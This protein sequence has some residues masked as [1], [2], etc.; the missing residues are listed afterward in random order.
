VGEFDDSQAQD[1]G[2]PFKH[3]GGIATGD[4]IDDEVPAGHDRVQ[5]DG[6]TNEQASS[7]EHSGRTPKTLEKGDA[8]L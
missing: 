6:K 3:E 8:Q 1:L 7:H 4:A 5:G 2:F